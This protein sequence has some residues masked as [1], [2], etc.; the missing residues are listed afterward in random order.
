MPKPTTVPLFPKAVKRVTS[1]VLTGPKKPREP[2]NS[3]SKP[4]EYRGGRQKGTPNKATV[5]FRDTINAIL[6]SNAENIGKWLS[7]IANGIPSEIDKDGNT[8]RVAV[9]AD[10]FRALGTIAALAEYAA[11]KL[12]RTEVTGANGAPLE[13][14]VLQVVVST[15]V[16]PKIEQLDG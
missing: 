16:T 15:N 9:A 7:Q 1:M 14:P 4:G 8:I 5:L 2:N 13:P 3:G 12:A 6:E 11:P 10:P